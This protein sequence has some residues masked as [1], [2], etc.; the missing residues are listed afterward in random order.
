MQQD[1]VFDKYDGLTTVL[2]DFNAEL[3]E[4]ADVVVVSPGVPV[5]NYGLSH[6]LQSVCECLLFL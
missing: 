2:G 1:P 6:L 5:E 3:L 4:H